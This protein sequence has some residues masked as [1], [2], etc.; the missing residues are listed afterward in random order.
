MKCYTC[1]KLALTTVTVC[2]K[3]YPLC[4]KCAQIHEKAVALQK[5]TA[6]DGATSK[7]D[8]SA[9]CTAKLYATSID[10]SEGDVKR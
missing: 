4:L 10:G 2:E 3:E 9:K 1:G 6:R 7:A 8:G 5:K